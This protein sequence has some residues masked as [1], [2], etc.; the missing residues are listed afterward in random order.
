[1]DKFLS[2]TPENRMA[3]FNKAE[4]DLGLSED[5]IEKDFWV[6]WILKELF[7]ME[8]IKENLTFKGGTVLG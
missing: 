6:C 2:L 8:M 1:M 5:L 3:V 7:Q 4:V